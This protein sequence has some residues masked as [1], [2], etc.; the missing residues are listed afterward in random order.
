[1]ADISWLT[2]RL[3]ADQCA[4]VADTIADLAAAAGK[5]PQTVALGVPD[6]EPTP[7]EVWTE[8]RA[9]RWRWGGEKKKNTKDE[10][11][12]PAAGRG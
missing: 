3:D 4:T 1:M 8:L 11:M 2:M 10:R 5:T 6:D 9:R 12:P 7:R